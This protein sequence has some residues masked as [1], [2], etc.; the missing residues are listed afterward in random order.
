LEFIPPSLTLCETEPGGRCK[1]L[2]VLKKIGRYLP[3]EEEARIEHVVEHLRV[4]DFSF[5]PIRIV[6]VEIGMPILDDFFDSFF[7]HFK[8]P[9]F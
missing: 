5:V 8:P 9:V 1:L 6:I 7:C 4:I 2:Q 3:K